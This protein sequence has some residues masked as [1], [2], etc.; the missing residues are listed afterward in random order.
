MNERSHDCFGAIAFHQIPLSKERYQE[1]NPPR[2]I[3]E[4][5]KSI[6]VRPKHQKPER[7]KSI[8]K[9]KFSQVAIQAIKVRPKRGK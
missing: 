6:Y 2:P 4:I 3:T 9:S 7:Q 5:V 1:Q 8:R